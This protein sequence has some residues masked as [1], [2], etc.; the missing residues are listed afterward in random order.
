[1]I[2]LYNYFSKLNI[3][4]MFPRI[5]HC[6]L[7]PQNAG[8]VQAGGGWHQ[9]QLRGPAGEV[10]PSDG[11]R[12]REFRDGG[13]VDREQGEGGEGEEKVRENKVREKG[14]PC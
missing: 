4:F 10:C 7:L 6:V 8:Q 13:A 1:M 5:E 9:H 3:V 14:L 11:H 12:Q 2:D